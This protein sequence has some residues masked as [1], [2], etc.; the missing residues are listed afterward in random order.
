MS[1]A[2][3]GTSTV[4]RYLDQARVGRPHLRQLALLGGGGFFDAFDI[5]L[6]GS[7]L[8]AMV[9]SGFSTV[10]QN[11]AFLSSTSFGLLVGTLLAGYLGDRFGRRATYLYALALYGVATLLTVAAGSHGLIVALR[12]LTGIGLG[13]VLITGYGTWN[14]FVPSRRRASWAGVLATV[15]N[16]AMPLSAIAGLLVIPP[17]GWRA[18][19]VVCGVPALVIWFL[20]LKFLDESPRWLEAHGR[21]EQARRIARKFNPSMPPDAELPAPATAATPPAVPF[22]DLFRKPLGRITAVCILIAV[23]NQIAF[24]TFESWVPTYLLDRGL[25]V[26][27]SLGLSVLMQLGA[28]PGCLIG[29][30]AGDRLGRK[31]VNVALFLLMGGVGIWYGYSSSTTELVISGLIWVFLASFAISVQIASYIPELFP[32]ELRLQGSALANACARGSVI[33]SPFLVSTTYAH[34]G[35]QG[36]FLGVM[37]ICV[38]GAVSVIV[39][40]PETRKRSLEE[41]ATRTTAAGEPADAL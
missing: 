34:I 32:T 23:C 6:S 40:A 5:F 30:L 28:I 8:A 33:I 35:V 2:P 9:A 39:L 41:I 12:A 27:K 38:I 14:E 1:H 3:G 22:R 16:L 15:V 11:A 18:M 10:G 29:G 25:S 19:F 7:V 20:Q 24:Y 31:W 37:G 26:E 36:V 17:F 4:G 13:A 21:H